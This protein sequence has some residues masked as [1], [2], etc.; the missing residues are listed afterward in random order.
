MVFDRYIFHISTPAQAQ[1]VL[2][3]I[4]IDIDVEYTTNIK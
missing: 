2:L 4:L 3:S 1:G